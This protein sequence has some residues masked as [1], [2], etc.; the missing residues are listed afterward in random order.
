MEKKYKKDQP[1]QKNLKTMPQEDLDKSRSLYPPS[2]QRDLY[3]GEDFQSLFKKIASNQSLSSISDKSRE[4]NNHS[5]VSSCDSSPLNIKNKAQERESYLGMMVSPE[6]NIWKKRRKIA[7][8]RYSIGNV[9]HMRAL[10]KILNQNPRQRMQTQQSRFFKRNLVKSSQQV[11]ENMPSEQNNSSKE[12]VGSSNHLKLTLVQ[13]QELNSSSNLGVTFGP[14][15]RILESKDSLA[16]PEGSQLRRNTSKKL[17]SLIQDLNLQSNLD[18]SNRVETSFRGSLGMGITP[19]NNPQH[20]RRQL[21]EANNRNRL[22]LG[23]SV[24]NQSQQKKAI[25]NQTFQ[26]E[27]NHLAVSDPNHPSN[28]KLVRANSSSNTMYKP[29]RFVEN[30]SKKP[31]IMPVKAIDGL[32][33]GQV[34][35]QLASVLG[36]PHQRRRFSIRM[37][38]SSKGG[39]LITSSLQGNF[40]ENL[41]NQKQQQV[42]P[43]KSFGRQKKT[44]NLRIQLLSSMGKQGKLTAQNCFKRVPEREVDAS[45]AL[46]T[47]VS[48]IFDEKGYSR[49]MSFGDRCKKL[50]K[51]NDSPDNQEEESTKENTDQSQSVL[52]H[53]DL[54]SSKGSSWRNKKDGA[55]QSIF[56]PP[57]SP[58]TRPKSRLQRSGSIPNQLICSGEFKKQQS[59]FN[60]GLFN[61]QRSFQIG[62]LL[63]QKGKTNGSSMEEKVTKSS[64]N[65]RVNLFE[66]KF[67]YRSRSRKRKLA[68][69]P[70]TPSDFLIQMR[71]KARPSGKK[72]RKNL[73]IFRKKP[74]PQQSIVKREDIKRGEFFLLKKTHKVNKVALKSVLE[75][76]QDLKG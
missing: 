54:K 11:D 25:L 45:P 3:K 35:S 66:G 9:E 30:L 44:N 64:N 58:F 29:I 37:K 28:F 16:L 31:Q 6:N 22:V 8:K 51:N 38:S 55:T 65:K 57:P 69:I 7:Q 13:K 15:T 18:V 73:T 17:E 32:K 60:G 63:S 10:S 43:I 67:V 61:K 50:E 39:N 12:R 23:N 41:K 42:Q 47:V 5:A 52:R 33:V 26:V 62:H 40:K 56:L 14:K 53:Q 34:G 21:S 27:A 71:K 75:A 72:S 59:S 46:R 20:L 70:Q 19:V 48:K 1:T 4:D 36:T 76:R 49:M 2:E 74:S 68:I 24:S